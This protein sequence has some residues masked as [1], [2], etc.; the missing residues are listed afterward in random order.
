MNIL[1][2]GC[3]SFINKNLLSYTIR[4]NDLKI[5]NYT[6]LN[7]FRKYLSQINLIIICS[8]KNN[9]INSKGDLDSSCHK[10]LLYSL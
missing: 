2:L 6:S 4:N 5:F 10:F 1:T 8:K 9:K 3:D 7:Q